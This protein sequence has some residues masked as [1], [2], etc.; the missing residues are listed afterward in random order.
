MLNTDFCCLGFVPQQ[1][2]RRDL[3]IGWRVIGRRYI[4]VFN[5]PYR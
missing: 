4:F 1:D 5:S 2:R 3:F